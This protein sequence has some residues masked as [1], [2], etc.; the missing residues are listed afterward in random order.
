MIRPAQEKDASSV[1]DLVLIVLKDMELSI[2]ERLTEVEVK[3][4]L[5]EAYINEPDHRYGF[6]NALVK[7]INQQIAGVLFSYPH[8]IEETI[9][10]GFINTL[11]SNGL[12]ADYRLFHEKETFKN[13]WYLDTLVT[14]IDYRGLGVAGELLDAVCELAKENNYNTV[15]L[16]VDK[17]NEHAKQ[18]YLKKGF[19]S[20]GEITI[21]N[22]LYEHLQKQID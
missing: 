14:S 22:H 12:T 19:K 21:S 20:I 5:M 17:I 3:S 8:S 13:E 7:E 6:H 1:I 9:D 2:F 4:L 15:G 11:L 18:I 16:N 10:E